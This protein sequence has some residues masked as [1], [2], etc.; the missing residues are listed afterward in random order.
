MRSAKTE[1]A[2]AENIDAIL[3]LE[4][5]DEKTR[6]LDHR[7]FHAIGGFVGTGRFIFLQCLAVGAWVAPNLYSS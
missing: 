6:A 4:K 5:H 2:A 7:V 1:T 3:R